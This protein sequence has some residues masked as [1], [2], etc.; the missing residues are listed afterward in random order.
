MPDLGVGEEGKRGKGKQGGRSKKQGKRGGKGPTFAS[1]P[2]A[3]PAIAVPGTLFAFVSARGIYA[4]NFGAERLLAPFLLAAESK[5]TSMPANSQKSGAGFAARA[6]SMPAHRLLGGQEPRQS[7]FICF[8]GPEDGILWVGT[9]EAV[10]GDRRWEGAVRCSRISNARTAP[11]ATLADCTWPSVNCSPSFVVSLYRM[12]VALMT[13]FA[14]NPL[15]W[16]GLR[17][18]VV[19][20]KLWARRT[21]PSTTP[22]KYRMPRRPLP[23]VFPS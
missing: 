12:R 19:H 7:I 6:T 16:H 23:L 8:L 4:C 15:F 18:V 13:F 5:A 21:P 17:G 1:P 3:L 20:A 9:P 10:A 14:P 22:K 11:K 2:L